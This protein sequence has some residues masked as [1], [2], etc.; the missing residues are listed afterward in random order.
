MFTSDIKAYLTGERRELPTPDALKEIAKYLFKTYGWVSIPYV[1]STKY[2][3]GKDGIQKDMFGTFSWKNTD[4]IKK[5][6]L[7][8]IENAPWDRANAIALATGTVSGNL[9]AIDLDDGKKVEGL[10]EE[11]TQ[12]YPIFVSKTRRGYHLIFTVM[13]END[14]PPTK[15]NVGDVHYGLIDTRGNGGIIIFPPSYYFDPNSK[16]LLWRYKL[17]YT[18]SLFR[19]LTHDEWESIQKV[20]RIFQTQK[21]YNQKNITLVETTHTS[22]ELEQVISV[23]KP[24]WVEGNRHELTWFLSLWLRSANVSKEKTRE[25]IKKI[26]KLAGDDEL[27]DRLRTVED[28]YENAD[29]YG[30]Y[31]G[32]LFGLMSNIAPSLNL[33]AKS[34]YFKLVEIIKHPSRYFREPKAY[35]MGF[36]K[37][38]FVDPV[39]GEVWRYKFIDDKI[40]NKKKFVPDTAIFYGFPLYI[41]RVETPYGV[42]FWRIKWVTKNGK[43]FTFE[44]DV[45]QIVSVMKKET[46]VLKEDSAKDTLSRILTAADSYGLVYKEIGGQPGFYIVNDKLM[47]IDVKL[48][49]YTIDNLRAS[50]G[51]LNKIADYFSH[52]PAHFATVIKWGLLAPFSFAIKQKTKNFLPWLYLFGQS[53]TGKTTLGQIVLFMWGVKDTKH[54]R[55]SQAAATPPR[56]ANILGQDTFPVLINEYGD[57][58]NEKFGMAEMI[59]NAIEST[60]SR[61]RM[62]GVD[63]M[64]TFY[65]LA[66]AML[67]SQRA[68]PNDIALKKR[69]YLIAF[70]FNHVRKHKQIL[71]FQKEIEPLFPQLVYIGA[72]VADKIQEDPSML[73]LDWRK[74]ADDLL[75]QLYHTVGMDVP[76]WA[77]EWLPFDWFEDMENEAP[78][79]VRQAMA[80]DVFQ[81]FRK[82]GISL[83]DNSFETAVKMAINTGAI[84]WAAYG[85]RSE[86]VYITKELM[87]KIKDVL[88]DQPLSALPELVG[89]K[90]WEYSLQKIDGKMVR[91]VAIPFSDFVNFLKPSVDGEEVKEDIDGKSDLLDY[92]EWEV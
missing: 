29:L 3:D 91:V 86:R 53:N 42:E 4:Y 43:E 35:R 90:S 62:Q 81:G 15:S 52:T 12:R 89:R 14:I 22:T 19:P 31:G 83:K 28:A 51:A 79:R 27:K 24:Y 17:I 20:L 78:R 16:E 87:T 84:Q 5:P 37:Y 67:T 77:G 30:F 68:T 41:T 74:V 47:P 10:I 70:G 80:E 6:S 63:T 9:V 85:E 21:V 61:E 44:G 45:N 73:N 38:I 75:Q 58:L 18:P 36:N 34:D 40:E 92:E 56:L 88:G 11:L 55:T 13:N 7:K 69:M 49:S 60:I 26:V 32:S 65:A 64:V 25:L 59:K 57:I 48:P 76:N 82:A 2:K 54:E 33:D 50:V 72:W 1:I 23:L 66:P 46:L 8:Q 39:G 71:E